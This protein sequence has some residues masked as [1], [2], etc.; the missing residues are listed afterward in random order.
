MT[1]EDFLSEL[2]KLVAAHRN[3]EALDLAQRQ[4]PV[5]GGAMTSE[6]V[7]RM[8]ELAHVAQMAVDLEEWDAANRAADAS[9][10][11]AS[12]F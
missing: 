3:Q 10:R 2:G 4:I 9:A 1:P 12:S 6:Q 11:S 7:V 5:L 8:A